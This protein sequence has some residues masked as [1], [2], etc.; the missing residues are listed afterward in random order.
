[1][2]NGVSPN[3]LPHPL[4]REHGEMAARQTTDRSEAVSARTELKRLSGLR[5][6]RRK[7]VR[8]RRREREENGPRGQTEAGNRKGSARRSPVRKSEPDD[9]LVRVEIEM[10]EH[11]S[12]RLGSQTGNKCPPLLLSTSNTVN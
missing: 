3:Q 1:M 12:G 2:L 8:K 9:R 11:P 4:T 7:N 5:K 10:F 6:K